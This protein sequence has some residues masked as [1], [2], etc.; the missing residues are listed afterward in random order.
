[1]TASGHYNK[2]AGKI[3]ARGP[4][5]GIALAVLTLVVILHTFSRKGGLIINNA[6]AIF[7]VCLLVVI[8]FLGIATAGGAFGGS[9]TAVADNFTKDVW[10]TEQKSPAS[11]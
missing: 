8:I 1:M 4:V 2:A 6:F 11:W 3:P 5:I 10:K 7:K 9:G